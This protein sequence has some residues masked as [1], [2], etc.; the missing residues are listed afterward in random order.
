[1]SLTDLEFEITALSDRSNDDKNSSQLRLIFILENLAN[2]FEEM[3]AAFSALKILEFLQRKFKVYSLMLGWF[4]YSETGKVSLSKAKP[5]M[6]MTLF[7]ES[8]NLK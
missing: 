8:T 5:K 1:M 7:V 4:D 6:C 2:K 3:L